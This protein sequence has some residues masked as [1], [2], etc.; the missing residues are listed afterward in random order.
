[1]N[2]VQRVLMDIVKVVD[3]SSEVSKNGV[4]RQDA[5]TETEQENSQVLDEEEWTGFGEEEEEADVKSPIAKST[6]PKEKKVKQKKQK[7]NEKKLKKEAD[8]TSKLPTNPFELIA[9]EDGDE[10]KEGD[11]NEGS[12]IL[13]SWFNHLTCI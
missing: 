6:V 12:F 1:M 9:E 11:D 4:S 2:G 7:K 8:A 13:V 3:K 5:S 10:G